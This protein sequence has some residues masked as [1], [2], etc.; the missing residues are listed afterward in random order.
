[1]SEPLATSPSPDPTPAPSSASSGD[2]SVSEVE[3]TVVIPAFNEMRRL[4]PSLD[5]IIPWL[6]ANAASWE[7][8]VC[9]DG[10]TDGSPEALAARYPRVRFV[11][12]P[13]NMGKGAAVRR[14]MLLARG[15]LVLFTD[16]DLSTPIEELGPMREAIRAKGYDVAIASRDL[17]DSRLEVRQPWWRELSGKTFNLL[18]RIVSGLP[19]ADTQCGFKLF[20]RDAARAIFLRARND[21]FAFDVEALL[22]ADLLG[23]RVLEVPVRWV[24]VEGSKVRLARDA[25]R[26]M[27]D[28]VRFRLNRMRGLYDRPADEAPPAD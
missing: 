11:P 27:A 10:S 3:V 6:D 18:V 8:L 25:P 12:A 1:M 7:I 2:A 23:L 16:A 26:M 24:D 17:P 28:I 15:G 5:A 19:Y 14:G 4:P 9:D 20:S 13:R 22:V 21:R